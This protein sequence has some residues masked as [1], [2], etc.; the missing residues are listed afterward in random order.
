MSP[1][2]KVLIAGCSDGGLGA[3]LAI[4]FDSAGLEV[5]AT[6]R[7]PS[8]MA[9]LASQHVGIKTLRMDVQSDSSIA[10]CVR[11]APPDLDIL[12]NNA[13]GGYNMPLPDLSIAEAKSLFDLN[14]CACLAVT[15][16]FLPSLMKSKSEGEGMGMIVN[17]TS[18]ASLCTVPF[19]GA[20]N[21]SKAAMATFLDTQRLELQP[22]GIRVVDL[23]TGLVESKFQNSVRAKKV[24]LPAGSIY[25]EAKEVV[26]RALQGDALESSGVSSEEWAKAV[27]SDLLHSSCST[28][29]RGNKA[30][31]VRI[32]SM[33]PF[34]SLD[35]TVNNLVGMSEVEQMIQKSLS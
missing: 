2:P 29:W 21:A 5:Y 20:Y 32:G 19:Q 35:G 33:L 27:V 9:S 30:W 14:V 6:A 23:K 4:A 16:A 26:E 13:G 8:K 17:H 25:T 34:G 1:P 15:Q 18:C 28:V 12:V 22:F 24:S 11:E 7:D 3:A 10:E 31:L